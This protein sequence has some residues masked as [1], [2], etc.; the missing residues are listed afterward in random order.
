MQVSLKYLDISNNMIQKDG[1]Y[2]IKSAIDM[3]NRVIFVN[4]QMNVSIPYGCLLQIEKTLK[5]NNSMI[6]TRVMPEYKKEI[7]S[8]KEK[9]NIGDLGKVQEDIHRSN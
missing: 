8:L 1:A 4:L 5:F 7:K 3:N 9:T 6:E 2:A